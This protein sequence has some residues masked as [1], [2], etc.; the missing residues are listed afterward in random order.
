MLELS[1]GRMT[2]PLPI[3]ASAKRLESSG[4]SELTNVSMAKTKSGTLPSFA[5]RSATAFAERVAK[6]GNV[7]DFVFAID[8]FVSSDS[9]LDSKRFA[10]AE[11]GNGFV[12]R[13]VDNSNITQ[14]HD[15]H[16]V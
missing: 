16:R 8:T 9:P 2:K 5:T 10:D 3:S 12:I 6:E 1:T 4:E 14:H 7:P 11:I 13:P 15:V